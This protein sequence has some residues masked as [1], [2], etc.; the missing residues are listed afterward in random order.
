L[1]FNIINTEHEQKRCLQSC[2]KVIECPD[3]TAQKIA[4]SQSVRQYLNQVLP[5]A[6]LVLCSVDPEDL[7]DREEFFES[8][9]G[10]LVKH[11][12]GKSFIFIVQTKYQDQEFEVMEKNL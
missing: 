4:T 6:D 9:L 10:G 3:E 5:L 7:K 8:R 11:N 12:N 2:L 1:D